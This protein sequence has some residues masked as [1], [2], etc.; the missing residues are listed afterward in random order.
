MF[1]PLHTP[2][3]NGIN[4]DKGAIGSLR[5]YLTDCGITPDSTQPGENTEDA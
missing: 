1:K 3:K 2:H 5:K 4:T